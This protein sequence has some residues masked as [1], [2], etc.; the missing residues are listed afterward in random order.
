M[1]AQDLTAGEQ[2]PRALRFVDGLHEAELCSGAAW[3]PVRW[4]IW[5]ALLLRLGGEARAT[6]ILLRN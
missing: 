3:E 2:E 6:N 4:A 1:L 5:T